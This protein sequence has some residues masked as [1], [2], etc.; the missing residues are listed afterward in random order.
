[1]SFIPLCWNLTWSKNRTAHVKNSITISSFPRWKPPL[2]HTTHAIQFLAR[3]EQ[4]FPGFPAVFTDKYLASATVRNTATRKIKIH[5][6]EIAFSPENQTALNTGI[7]AKGLVWRCVGGWEGVVRVG[8]W[9]WVGW[10]ELV[11]DASTPLSHLMTLCQW[12]YWN[13]D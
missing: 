9:V 4:E 1:M 5:F 6:L 2:S 12:Q 3:S 7:W 10:K 8:V 11:G 13:H